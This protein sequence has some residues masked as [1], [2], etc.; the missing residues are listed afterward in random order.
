MSAQLTV[1]VRPAC[2]LCDQALS[3]LERITTGMEVA[4]RV[5]DIEEDAVLHARYLERIPVIALDGE[6]L[7]DFFVD[8]ADLRARLAAPRTH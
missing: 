3:T 6:E 2:H 8:E 5:V 4:L 7:Y 1:Y